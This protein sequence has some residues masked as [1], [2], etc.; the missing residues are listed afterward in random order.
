VRIASRA[1]C[2]ALVGR[3]TSIKR[4]GVAT[5]C[6]LVELGPTRATLDANHPLAG[7]TI[8]VSIALLTFER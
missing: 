2:D 5:D 6:L 4:N 7:R 3:P 1:G 8:T